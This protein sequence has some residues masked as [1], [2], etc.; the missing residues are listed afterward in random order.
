MEKKL[1]VLSDT[2]LNIIVENASLKYALERL[3]K[4]SVK[5]L[6]VLDLEERLVAA[7]T[8]GEDRKSVV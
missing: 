6:L 3:D 4:V 1:S 7:L 2:S 5:V 8:D